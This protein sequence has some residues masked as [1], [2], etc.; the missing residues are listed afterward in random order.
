MVLRGSKIA[1]IYR[2]GL[3]VIRRLHQPRLLI[4][5]LTNL[6]VESNITHSSG[7]TNIAH[8]FGS[9]SEVFMAL[10]SKLHQS[11][12]LRLSP[13]L[14]MQVDEVAGREGVSLNHFIS[15]ALVEKLARMEESQVRRN[16]AQKH[17]R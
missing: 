10:E 13:S 7:L 9:I 4:R 8:S 17:S 14:R 16:M 11:F 12:P 15:M 2:P 5:Q 3:A 1:G 6:T